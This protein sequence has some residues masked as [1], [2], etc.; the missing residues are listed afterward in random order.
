[1]YI[2]SL[3]GTVLNLTSLNLTDS[4]SQVH[5]NSTQLRVWHQATRTEDLTNTTYGTHHIRGSNSYI[6]IGP[7]ALNL[8]YDFIGANEVCASGLSLVYLCTLGKYQYT[9]GLTSAMWQ[10]HCATNLLISVLRIYTQTH[11]KLNGLVELCSCSLLYEL[12]SLFNSINLAS[13]KKL[14]SVL[15][16][17]TCFCHEKI[18]PS[19]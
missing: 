19:W 6:K 18:L 9:L 15:I 3:I 11:M 17:L 5:S 2:T 8:C 12:N 10:H 14:Y 4:L 7:T 1:M 13:L 16:L